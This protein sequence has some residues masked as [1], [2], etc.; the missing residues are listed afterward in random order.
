[1]SHDLPAG[2]MLDGA[3]LVGESAEGLLASV[4]RIVICTARDHRQI[5]ASWI[6][7]P[8]VR[9]LLKPMQLDDFEGAI[10]W[11]AGGETTVK[12][13]CASTT[14]RPRYGAGRRSSAYSNGLLGSAVGQDVSV[15]A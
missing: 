9:V 11:L 3:A 15:G 13:G 4:S 2:L 14:R 8:H 6:Q 7:H 1:M 12:G 10:G 5:A